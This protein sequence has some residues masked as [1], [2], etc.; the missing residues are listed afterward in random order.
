MLEAGDKVAADARLIEAH[1]LTTALAQHGV[2]C[3]SP[4]GLLRFAPHWS[5]SLDEVEFVRQAVTQAVH[6]G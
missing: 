2:C 3:S 1:A 4:D 5:N 6:S